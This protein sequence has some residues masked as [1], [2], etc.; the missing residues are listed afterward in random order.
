VG[1]F[2]LTLGVMCTLYGGIYR[3]ALRLQRAAEARRSRM[4]SSLVS[5]ASH[6]ITRIGLGVSVGTTTVTAATGLPDGDDANCRPTAV[7]ELHNNSVDEDQP[8]PTSLPDH[9]ES[10]ASGQASYEEKDEHGMTG[11]NV[12]ARGD[13][14]TGS[15]TESR[16]TEIA[17]DCVVKEPAE[18]TP[19]LK[20]ARRALNNSSASV[21]STSGVDGSRLPARSVT[22]E[23]RQRWL[24]VLPGDQDEV[25]ESWTSSGAA[26]NGLHPEKTT[27]RHSVD[28]GRP[29]ICGRRT[30]SP[31][32]SLFELPTY[33]EV[34][35]ATTLAAPS[36]S[37]SSCSDEFHC[38]S[39]QHDCVEIV[40]TSE[41]MKNN[42]IDVATIDEHVNSTPSHCKQSSVSPE[43]STADKN[44]LTIDDGH[45]AMATMTSFVDKCDE[46][47]TDGCCGRQIVW[48]TKHEHEQQRK[49]DESAEKKDGVGDAEKTLRS[50]ANRW[51]QTARS[52]FAANRRFAHLRHWKMQRRPT[53]RTSTSSSIND[54][55]SMVSLLPLLSQPPPCR[56]PLFRTISR[57]ALRFTFVASVAVLLI[58]CL[59][60]RV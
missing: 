54:R 19:L 6:A 43:R 15:P 5:V 41:E 50:M 42:V 45:V 12:E 31:R 24:V 11:N 14:D 8:K 10:F 58:F 2:W 57:R 49:N 60:L 48:V 28:A 7:A 34:S 33:A 3:V 53:A 4:A 17:N 39:Q 27:V 32:R 52:H 55:Q 13:G 40:S 23:C 44:Q 16:R 35:P 56:W 20:H 36:S 30:R 22:S 18:V 51:R 59:T 1:Y 38:E 9:P 25:E 21:A 29:R 37:S 47:G 26:V 46:S